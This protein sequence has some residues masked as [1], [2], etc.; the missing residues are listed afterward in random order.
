[1]AERLIDGREGCEKLVD[2]S[3]SRF[4]R[5]QLKAAMRRHPDVVDEFL[6]EREASKNTP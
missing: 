3:R 6:A 1:L 4:Q 2:D 5:A